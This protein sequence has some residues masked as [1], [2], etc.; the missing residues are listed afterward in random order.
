MINGATCNGSDVTGCNE[1]PPTV[2]AG[3]GVNSVAVDPFTHE[4]YATNNEDATLSAIN[5]TVCNRFSA[6]GCGLAPPK[7]P[8]GNYPSD[9][10]IDPA[11][12]TLYVDSLAGISVVPLVP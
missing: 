6:Y 1:L 3:F 12:G 10:A 5:G 7:L 4:V 11:I 2:A 9:M 8:A